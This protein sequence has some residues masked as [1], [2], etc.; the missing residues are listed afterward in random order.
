MSKFSSLAK[1]WNQCIAFSNT[2]YTII[3]NDDVVFTDPSVLVKIHEKH[4]EGYGIVHATENWSGFSIRKSIIPKVGWFDERFTHSWED[5]DYRLRMKRKNVDY[6]RFEPNIIRHTRS[7]RGRFQDDWDRSSS[8]FFTKWGIKELLSL[9]DIS[10]VD[11]S[12]PG[13]R[14]Q[15]LEIGFFNDHFYDNLY[16]KVVEIDKTPDFYPELTK[17]YELDFCNVIEDIE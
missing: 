13:A 6:Y 12:D 15:L 11:T 1:C 7:T 8:H 16:D 9:L 17:Q 3:L 14:K 10:H 4:L 2:E 5:A